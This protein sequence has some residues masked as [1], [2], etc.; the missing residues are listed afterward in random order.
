MARNALV[1]VHDRR[2]AAGMAL[3]DAEMPGW[4]DCIDLR[5]LDLGSCTR[6]VVGQLFDV[7]EDERLWEGYRA[8]GVAAPRR[9]GFSLDWDLGY[10]A[11]YG[12]LTRAWKRAIRQRRR[13]AR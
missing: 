9:Y 5:T 7:K 2:I 13:V 10:R 6:C 4:E 3:L 1:T 8:L 11:T 12:G